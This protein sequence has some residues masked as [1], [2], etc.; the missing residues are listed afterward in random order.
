MIIGNMAT[1]PA[2]ESTLDFVVGN[3][4]PQL[5]RLNVVLNQYA[6]PPGFLSKHRN[7]VPILPPRD[8]RDVGKF[9]PDC[10]D[11]ALVFLLDDDI[12]Y[13]DDYVAV[14]TGLARAIG[15]RRAAMSH[16]GILFRKLGFREKPQWFKHVLRYRR[17]IH[18][19]VDYFDFRSEVRDSRVVDMI[20]TG[21]SLFRPA[22]LPDL[23]YMTGSDTS[24]D[25]RIGLWCLERG[26]SPIVL[27]HPPNWIKSIEYGENIH[28]D[29]TSRHKKSVADE[30]WRFAFKQKDRGM[31]VP[32]PC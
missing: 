2:R 12:I 31:V 27:K 9:L 11:A 32:T 5:D 24:V 17:H 6:A 23:A 7:V 22:D 19:Y 30:I 18:K 21:V 14:S 28:R 20:G 16:H 26:I 8:L 15:A 10:R 13:P 3:I 1:Y 29:H 25:V 4:A